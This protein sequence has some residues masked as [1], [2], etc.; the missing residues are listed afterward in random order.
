MMPDPRTSTR[1]VILNE[2][3]RVLLVGAEGLGYWAVPGGR[4]Q[5]GERLVEAAA[6]QVSALLGAALDPVQLGA[7]VAASSGMEMG[8]GGTSLRSRT[9]YF[10]L[11][12]QPEVCDSVG[13]EHQWWSVEEVDENPEV[14]DPEGLATL[15]RRLSSGPPPKHPLRLPPVTSGRR[16]GEREAGDP[17]S[18]KVLER[19]TRSEPH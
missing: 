18:P 15:I 16:H 8:P 2:D 11:R 5:D 12:I 3:N 1:V 7:A 4:V 17:T 13:V 6:R 14:V 10:Q 19:G 9:M